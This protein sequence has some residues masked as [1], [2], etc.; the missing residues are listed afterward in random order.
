MNHIFRIHYSVVRHMG[1]FQLLA[2]TNKA[3]MNVV[4][5]ALLWHGV[6]SFGYIPKSGIAWSIFCGTSRFISRVVVPVCNLTS[7]GGVFLFLHLIF[8]LGFLVFSFLRSLCIYDIPLSDVGLTKIFLPICKLTICLIGY[9]FCHT[10]TFQTHEVPFI[11]S[12]PYNISPYSF[13]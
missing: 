7:N 13:V 2:I 3:T 12:W 6:L 1:C 11:N 8:W 5:N 4:E 10:E 9:A